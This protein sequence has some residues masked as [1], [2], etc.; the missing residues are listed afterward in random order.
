MSPAEAGEVGEGRAGGDDDGVDVVLMHE[1]AGA[2]ETLLAFGEGDGNG[3]GA[4]VGEGGDA[5]REIVALVR[6]CGECEG[7]RGRGCCGRGQE[8][9]AAVE[10]GFVHGLS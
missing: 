3:L 8:E 6:L 4:A 2:V 5:G 9:S 1:G 7:G 10:H